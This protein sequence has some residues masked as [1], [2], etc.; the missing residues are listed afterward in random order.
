M[1]TKKLYIQTIGCQMNVYDSGRIEQQ[2]APLNYAI[3]EEVAEA[4]LVVVNTCAIREK[5]EQ[6][7]FSFLGRMAGLKR[8]RPEL[9]IGVGGC[10]AQQLGERIWKRAPYVDVVFGTH[11]I[12]RLGALIAK[13][14]DQ[15]RRWVD[16]A[17]SDGIDAFE[18]PAAPVGSQAITRFVTIMQGCDNYCTYCV[19]PYVRGSEAS[20][21]PERIIEEIEHLVA[22]GVRE[23][24]LLGQNVNSYGRKEGHC[25]FPELLSRVNA[26]EH[27]YRI[28]FT[29]SHP[30]DLSKDL[31]RSFRDLEKLCK[32][33]HLPVQSG[34]NRVLKRMNRKYT[35]EQY[36]EKIEQLRAFCP[37]IAIS[38]D[39][40]TG[41]PGET[42]SDFEETLDLIRK[43]RFDSLFAFQYSD[44]PNARAAR[45]GDKVG[46]EEKSRRLQALLQ[47][48]EQIT[49][50]KHRDLVGSVQEVLV[51][52]LRHK[53]AAGGQPVAAVDGNPH[54]Q[55]TG[56]TSTN[57]IVHFERT[58][59]STSSTRAFTGKLV[60]V[61]IQKAHAHSLWGVPA[62]IE[63]VLPTLKGAN[64]HAA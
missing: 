51:E 44:R 15:G 57:R 37:G 60:R 64:S 38:S 12:G 19:V 32:H 58:A 52:G 26:I 61:T 59:Q 30:K 7:V 13:V 21:S 2:L 6:K 43:V 24:T 1:Y 18:A 25:S 28:R 34:S 14:E 36:C 62:G 42:E 23:V 22:G 50:K 49:L 55:W 48:Q 5:A 27:L 35:H 41:F 53:V 47:L 31:C 29:T 11:A 10:V 16:V 40:I 63:P 9:I 4:D 3:T 17:L 20:R 8:K 54:G 45:F 56:R 33:I 46:E 39:F